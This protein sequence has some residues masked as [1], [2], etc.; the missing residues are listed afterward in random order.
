M[1]QQTKDILLTLRRAGALNLSEEEIDLIFEHKNVKYYVDIREQMR[2]E[3][4]RM[5]KEDQEAYFLLERSKEIMTLEGWLDRFYLTTGGVM[6]SFWSFVD[7]ELK[8]VEVKK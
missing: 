7:N 8:E 1:T 3:I 2:A 6:D 4:R 5:S